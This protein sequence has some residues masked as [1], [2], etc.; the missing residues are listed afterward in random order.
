M[1]Y[2]EVMPRPERPIRQ[3]I[4]LPPGL[5]H[6]VK[7]LARAKKASTSRVVVDLIEAGLEGRE[8]EKKRFLDLADRL[9]RSSD[10]GEQRRLKEELARITFGE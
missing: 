10:P 2:R 5:A 3:S 9:V 8:Q 6:R 4:S 7:A 1:V